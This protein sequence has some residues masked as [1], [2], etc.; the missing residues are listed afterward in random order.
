MSKPITKI[1]QQ[2]TRCKFKLNI[3]VG[4]IHIL[5]MLGNEE[6]QFS[7]NILKSYLIK[8]NVPKNINRMDTQ[9]NLAYMYG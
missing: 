4:T 2:K 1:K 5:K 6:Y 3:D 9:Q 7:F 8:Y